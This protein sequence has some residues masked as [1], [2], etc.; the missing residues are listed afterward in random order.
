MLSK[1]EK[2]GAATAAERRQLLVQSF[3]AAAA[4][5]LE[6]V[7]RQVAGALQQHSKV[8][9]FAHHR[10]MLD[11]VQRGALARVEHVRI[12]GTT[13]PA[14]RH[15]AVRRFQED[16]TVRAALVGITVGGTALTL[17]AASVVCFLELYWTPGALLQAEDRVHRIGQT[18]AAVRVEYWLGADTIDEILWPL[19]Q[20]KAR[21]VGLAIG[22]APNGLAVDEVRDASDPDRS[23][24]RTSRFFAPRAAAAGGQAATASSA[25][26][27]SYD[28]H[29]GDE[30]AADEDGGDG[31][32]ALLLELEALDSEARGGAPSGEDEGDHGDDAVEGAEERAAAGAESD[33]E[34]AEEGAEVVCV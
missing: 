22:G 15:D 14:A 10:D 4:T 31:G 27:A 20:R 12:D 7:Q 16:A 9:F 30:A 32:D 21:V 25:G 5:K 11:G 8:V 6:A 33:A 17:T 23:V 28:G 26:A 13:P 1:E 18:A 29:D 24:H 2:Q 34:D 3:H 19:L